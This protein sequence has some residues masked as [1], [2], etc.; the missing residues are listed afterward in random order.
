MEITAQIVGG[1]I[2]SIPVDSGAE[3]ASAVTFTVT[4]SRLSQECTGR[5]EVDSDLL[6]VRLIVEEVCVWSILLNEL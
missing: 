4:D 2:G 1:K 6:E 5:L 3:G